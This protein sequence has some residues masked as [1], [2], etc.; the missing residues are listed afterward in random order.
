MKGE[1]HQHAATVGV[2]EVTLYAEGCF[3]F[4]TGRHCC[5]RNASKILVQL[6]A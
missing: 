2:V 3:M 1:Q 4:N 6:N 5:M